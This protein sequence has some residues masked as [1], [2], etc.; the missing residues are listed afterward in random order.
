MLDKI[1]SNYLCIT[2]IINHI[3]TKRHSREKENN[4]AKSIKA[5][6]SKRYE[7]STKMHSNINACVR[8]KK[9]LSEK[10]LTYESD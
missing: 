7:R 3:K 8:D 2:L 4:K 9:L 6:R 5:K 1:K 10:K